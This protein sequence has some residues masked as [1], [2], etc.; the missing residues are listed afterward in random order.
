MIAAI[1]SLGLTLWLAALPAQRSHDDPP[2]AKSSPKDDPLVDA[3]K[4]TDREEWDAA[5]DKFRA[6]LDA[7]PNAPQAPEAR[8]WAGF[9]LVKLGESDE[10]VAILNPFTDAL[11][12]DRWADDALLQIGKALRALGKESDALAT[13]KRHLQKYPQSVWRTEVTLAVID[14]L[15]YDATDLTTC[16]SYCRQLTQEVQDRDSTIEARY[17]GAYCLNALRKYDDSEAWADRLFD[18]E[19]AHG[20][21]MA[22]AAR[23]SGISFGDRLIGAQRDGFPGHRLSRSRRGR[24]PGPALEDDLHPPQQRPG[25]PG[26]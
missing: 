2:Q 16:L 4:A 5:A 19:S 13:W 20:R 9:C 1:A 25:R 7:R 18:P 10:A 22:T 3:R 14:L 17:L 6:F 24:T 11:A 8:F 15:F 12:G 21:G 26:P 23:R